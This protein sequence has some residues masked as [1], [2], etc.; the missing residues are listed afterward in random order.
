MGSQLRVITDISSLGRAEAREAVMKLANKGKRVPSERCPE[1][2]ICFIVT[3]N[4]VI[5][6]H[7]IRG[8]HPAVLQEFCQAHA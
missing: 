6:E 5:V 1:N 8:L 2:H 4:L 7:Q 3:G